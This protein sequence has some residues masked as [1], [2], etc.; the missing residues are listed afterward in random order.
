MAEYNSSTTV[1]LMLSLLSSKI[2]FDGVQTTA[3][4]LI[5]TKSRMQLSYPNYLEGNYA[6]VNV[7][8]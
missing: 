2:Y 6:P 4:S 7:E 1:H 8:A 3:C 5:F